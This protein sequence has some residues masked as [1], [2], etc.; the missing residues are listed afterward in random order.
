MRL[1]G[2]FVEQANPILGTF[3]CVANGS[4]IHLCPQHSK[5]KSKLQ[6]GAWPKRQLSFIDYR[7]PIV[8]W[9][10]EKLMAFLL[11]GFAA[12]RGVIIAVIVFVFVV[13][14]HEDFHLP[15]LKMVGYRCEWNGNPVHGCPWIG[16]VRGCVH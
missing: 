9:V 5:L 16:C 10:I 15:S 1:L 8:S 12:R 4:T 7:P 6:M 14:Y 3:I 13:L 11:Q 2:A